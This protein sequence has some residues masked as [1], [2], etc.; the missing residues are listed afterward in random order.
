MPHAKFRRQK[1]SRLS[2][3]DG[4]RIEDYRRKYN[5]TMSEFAGYIGVS[6]PTVWSW[7]TAKVQPRKEGRRL[8]EK[9]LGEEKVEEKL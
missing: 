8:L 9:L 1:Q 2:F 5:L 4:K 7:E 3:F 6:L